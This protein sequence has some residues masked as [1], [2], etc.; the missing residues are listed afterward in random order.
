MS[1]TAPNPQ[2]P[3]DATFGDVARLVGYDLEAADV[4]SGGELPVTLH[5]QALG[6][7]ERPL[8][9]FVHLVDEAGN[10]RG[11]GDSEPGGGQFPTTGWL[12][13]EYHRRRAHRHGRRGCAAG[14]VSAGGGAIRS[15]DGRDACS[16]R[17]ARIMWCWISEVR[18]Q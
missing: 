14:R 3:T 6:A 15:G 9:V 8:T 10:I 1:M 13:G 12:P 2:H 18:S 4:I 16:P 11:Y 7:T 5:W 17:R